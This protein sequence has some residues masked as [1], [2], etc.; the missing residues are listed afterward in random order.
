MTVVLDTNVVL[1]AIL[2]G[3]KPRQV[4][5]AALSGTIRL[6][7]SEPMI[8][9]LQSVLQ[10][11]KFGVSAQFVQTIV[12]EFAAIAEWVEP[13]EHFEVVEDDPTD[14]QFIDCAVAAKA[15]YLV[16]GDSHLLR[17]GRYGKTKIVNVDGFITILSKVKGGKE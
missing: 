12:S 6:F 14:N 5:E 3:G 17:H 4:L 9:E 1:S 8:T 15:D 7:V 10:R 13:T 16:T 2:F 11:P